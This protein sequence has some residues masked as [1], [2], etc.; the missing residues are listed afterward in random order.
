ML[1]YCVLLGLRQL[2]QRYL[3]VRP[4]GLKRV[5]IVS[6]QYKTQV[7]VTKPRRHLRALFQAMYSSNSQLAKTSRAKR[8]KPD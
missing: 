7:S 1:R 8:P 3:R 6:I 5:C 4:L 2:E